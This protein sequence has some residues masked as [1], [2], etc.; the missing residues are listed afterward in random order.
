[1]INIV[2]F[3]VLGLI[4]ALFGVLLVRIFIQKQDIIKD[5]HHLKAILENELATKLSLQQSL[6]NA[7]SQNLIL[8][9]ENAKLQ[10]RLKAHFETSQNLLKEKDSAMAK[11]QNDYKEAQANLE[12]KYEKTLELIKQE[13]QE[14]FT[15]QQEALLNENRV[16]LNKDSRKLMDEIFTPIQKSIKEYEDRLTKNESAIKTNIEKM[17]DYSKQIKDDA[18][19]FARILSGEKKIRGNFAEIQLKSVLQNSGLLEGEHYKLQQSFKYE[20]KTY[21][22]DAVVSLDKEKSFA[23]DAKFSLPDTQSLQNQNDEYDDKPQD[24]KAQEAQKEILCKELAQNL[25][26]RIDELAAKPYEKYNLYTYDFIF[27]FIPY[28]NILDLALSADSTLYQYASKKNIYLATPY[29]LFMALKA[30]NISWRHTDSNE[31]VMRAFE[32]IKKIRDKFNG[33]IDDFEKIKRNIGTLNNS[34][35]DLDKKLLSG[36]GNFHKRLQDIEALELKTQKAIA[37]N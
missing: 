37:E 34:I 12:S 9:Q 20:G 33:V 13:L 21:I 29:I 2:A 28:Q 27:L 1:M 24:T 18:N 16:A 25:K 15:K 5:Y 10:E 7:E 14:R 36:N 17:F 31:K 11:A 22:I 35:G 32:E 3:V 4:V 8:N 6:Q 26:A 19:K 23:V 30:V